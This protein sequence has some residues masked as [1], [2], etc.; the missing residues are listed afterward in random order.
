VTPQDHSP[1]GSTPSGS[2]RPDATVGTVLDLAAQLSRHLRMLVVVPAA[3]V[4]AFVGV[5]LLLGKTYTT[6]ISFTPVAPETSAGA[7]ASLAGQFGI[8][9]PAADPSGSPDFYADL[10]QTPDVLIP[11]AES[12]YSVVDGRDSLTGTLLELLEI[13]ESTPGRTMAE[14]LKELRSEIMAVKFDRQTSIVRVS[15]KTDWPELSFAMANRLLELVDTFNLKSRQTTGGAQ[16]NFLRQRVDTARMELSNAEERLQSFL[17]QNR[18]YVNDPALTFE[19]DRRRREV[20]L[21]QEVYTTLVQA[22]E[23]ARLTAVRNTPSVSIVERPALPLRHDRRHLAV[24]VILVGIAGLFV[25][26]MAALALEAIAIERLERPDAFAELAQLAKTF[27]KP[28]G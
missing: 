28:R 3:S 23:Q 4:F 18:S 25:A 5:A 12:R 6:T 14:G 27:T 2:V 15:I 1:G 11:L 13:D 17:V 24:K 9:L 19:H 7:L 26:V 8:G 20:T 16:Q 22:Y 10:L 21:R